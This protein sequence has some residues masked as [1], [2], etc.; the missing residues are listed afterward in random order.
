ME[1]PAKPVHVITNDENFIVVAQHYGLIVQY[2]AHDIT[3][4]GIYHQH[5]LI[6]WPIKSSAGQ[7]KLSPARRTVIKRARRENHCDRC[8]RYAGVNR[9]QKCGT[10]Y[11]LLW[12]KENQ[13]ERIPNTKRYIQNKLDQIPEADA[14]R[15]SR[16]A[17]RRE[18]ESRR[19]DLT[20]APPTVSH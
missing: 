20:E 4:E 6:Y 9:C 10:Y 1:I 11:K 8:Q 2:A 3:K 5:L 7:D 14:L 15:Y 18:W 16:K 13:P 17:W 12:A 19:Q